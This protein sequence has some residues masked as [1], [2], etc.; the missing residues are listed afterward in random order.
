MESY[1]KFS[2]CKNCESWNTLIC[3]FCKS[4]WQCPMSDTL[5]KTI[6]FHIPCRITLGFRVVLSRLMDQQFSH[7]SLTH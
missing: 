5:Y 1:K 4:A 7:S 6:N 2:K 3:L